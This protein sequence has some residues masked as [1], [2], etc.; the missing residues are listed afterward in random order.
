MSPT[1]PPPWLLARNKGRLQEAQRGLADR[2]SGRGGVAG[3]CAVTDVCF[4]G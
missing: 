4:E 2:E 3:G 1:E